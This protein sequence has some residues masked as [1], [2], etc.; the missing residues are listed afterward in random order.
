[1][2]G[3]FLV[4]VGNV[5]YMELIKFDSNEEENAKL[6]IPQSD[7]YCLAENDNE[8]NNDKEKLKEIKEYENEAKE[9]TGFFSKIAKYFYKEKPVN[10]EVNV[11]DEKK[12]LN[13]I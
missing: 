7:N 3:Y 9:S 5:I 4:M 10:N 13:E 12:K 1:M 2:G 8:N 6:P 11:N